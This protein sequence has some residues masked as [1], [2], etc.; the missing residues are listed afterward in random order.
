MSAHRALLVLLVLTPL[1]C[2]RNDRGERATG[3]TVEGAGGADAT[4][5]AERQTPQEQPRTAEQGGP[6]AVGGGPAVG[7]PEDALQPGAAR[8][9]L[10]EAICDQKE[11]ACG[12]MRDASTR[13]LCRARE[14]AALG[15]WG[16]SCASFRSDALTKCVDAVKKQ[17]CDQAAAGLPDACDRAQ[18]CTGVQAAPSP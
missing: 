16:A 4:V 3:V 15:T 6:S 9:R 10:T 18:V 5:R 8:A 17:S 11:A 13:S 2:E 7:T 1:A 12:V 14:Y